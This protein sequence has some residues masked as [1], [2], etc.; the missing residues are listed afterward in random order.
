M[1]EK[2]H[3]VSDAD[4]YRPNVGIVLIN[5]A[6]QVLWARRS[7]HDGWQFPQGG[8]EQGETLEQAA[9]RELYEEVGLRPQNVEL[10]GRTRDWLRYDVPGSLRSRSATFK[11]QKQVW[12]LMKLV[13]SDCTICLDHSDAPEFDRWQWVD[14]WLPPRKVVSLNAVSTSLLYQNLSRCCASS[15]DGPRYQL[16]QGANRRECG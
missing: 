11:G 3:S 10:V 8:I 13:A 9:Y 12:F 7:R 16:S 4:G 5:N 6:G 1:D 14:Y 2:L 15:E